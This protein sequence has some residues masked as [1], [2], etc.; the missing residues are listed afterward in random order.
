MNK[1]KCFNDLIE[2]KRPIIIFGAGVAGAR[3]FIQIKKYP[4]LRECTIFC[5][6]FKKGN[7]KFTGEKI[8][9]F[10]DAVQKYP[11]AVI[12]LTIAS[13]VL[14]DEVKAQITDFRSYNF[15]II[16][17][18][19]LVTI[20]DNETNGGIP[21]TDAEKTFD[22]TIHRSQIENIS[23]WID[24]FDHSVIDFGAGEAYLKSCL[25]PDV[26]YTPTDYIA[27]TPEYLVYDF[28]KH[29]FPD[30]TADVSVLFQ[31]FYYIDD[32]DDFIKNVC[33]I[34]KNKIIVGIGICKSKTFLKRYFTIKD[35]E[36]F[37]KI[38]CDE[39]W[40]LSKKSVI[41]RGDGS[42]MKEVTYLFKKQI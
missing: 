19:D 5:D 37:V 36:K 42:V 38:I 8:F 9:T 13:P 28:N 30:I 3:V 22:W 26:K 10:K 41:N 35:E 34:T 2:S 40:I 7:E 15:E 6:N 31:I 4:E 24:E 20:I 33:R 27:R 14:R 18:P 17:W 11:N 12:L 39:G 21:W 32:L 25:R 16:D 1:Y 29:E 23:N